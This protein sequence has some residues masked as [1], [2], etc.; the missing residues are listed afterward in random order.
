[1]TPAELEILKAINSEEV[2][3]F[4]PAGRA[5]PKR[6]RPDGRGRPW[7]WRMDLVIAV[8]SSLAHLAGALNRPV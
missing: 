7:R 1:M 8:D 4:L 5:L 3:T 6:G 2:K